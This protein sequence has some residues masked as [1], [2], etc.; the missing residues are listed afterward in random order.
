MLAYSLLKW[1]FL[2]YT[3][4]IGLLN[5]ILCNDYG[6]STLDVTQIHIY[7][8]FK[9]SIHSYLNNLRDPI[10]EVVRIFF[11]P[12]KQGIGHSAVQQI[13]PL[14]QYLGLNLVFEIL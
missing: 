10:Y 3:R 6:C 5:I 1:D 14:L 7:P 12:I 11:H 9:E 4:P 8:G 2:F 13:F